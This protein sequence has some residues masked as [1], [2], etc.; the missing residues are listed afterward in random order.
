[1]GGGN[2]LIMVDCF[3]KSDDNKELMYIDANNLYGHSR[4]QLVTYDEIKS[5]RH[6]TLEDIITTPDD[7][8]LCFLIEVDLK[9]YHEIKQETKHLSSENEVSPQDKFTIHMIDM[10][11]KKCKKSRKSKCDWIDKNNFL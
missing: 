11:P 2:S 10:K 7:R 1:M 6:V 5:T 8:F 9:Y 4:S 3:E